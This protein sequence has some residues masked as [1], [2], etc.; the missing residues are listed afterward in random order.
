MSADYPLDRMAREDRVFRHDDTRPWWQAKYVPQI[1]DRITYLEEAGFI[2]LP[3]LLSPEKS[4]M[5]AKDEQISEGDCASSSNSGQKRV[6]MPVRHYTGLPGA[7]IN[8]EPVYDWLMDDGSVEA[9][10]ASD[11]NERRAT[12]T[13]SREANAVSVGDLASEFSGAL[14]EAHSDRMARALLAKFD[15]RPKVSLCLTEEGTTADNPVTDGT[16]SPE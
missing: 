5:K 2:V 7:S 9:L 6:P 12:L 16:S 1:E 8:G 4:G 15:I 11:V 10:T 14:S 3:S 13:A